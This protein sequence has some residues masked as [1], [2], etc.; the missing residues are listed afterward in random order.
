VVE[1]AA[2]DAALGDEGDH[3]HHASAA[4]TD[5]RVDLVHPSDELRPAAAKG[6]QRGGRGATRERSIRARPWRERLC[7]LSLAAGLQLAAHDVRVGAVVVDEVATRIGDVGEEAGH[8][9]EGIDGLRLLVVVADPGLVSL[10]RART[11]II[12]DL[13]AGFTLGGGSGP[14]G[15]R[16]IQNQTRPS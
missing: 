8:E 15:S 2:D 10:F 5:E 14:S 16:N 4:G 6:G 7:L 13:P 1:D 9:V 11:R 12:Y 3:P